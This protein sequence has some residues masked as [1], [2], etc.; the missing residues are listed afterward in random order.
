LGSPHSAR[1]IILVAPEGNIDPDTVVIK[2]A[3]ALTNNPRRGSER[4]NIVGE[5]QDARNL[6]A[7]ELV[8]GREVSWVPVREVIG[9]LTVQTCRQSGLSAVHT[10]L[11][12]FGGDE[13][14]FTTQPELAGQTYFDAQLAFSTS[15]VFG[16]ARGE[17]VMLNPDAGMVL[18]PDD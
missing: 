18:E 2:M 4:L 9:R 13:I 1:S 15:S 10:E 7:A 16:V 8:G 11:L 17:T 3:L 12:D 6:E 14:Y 5:L